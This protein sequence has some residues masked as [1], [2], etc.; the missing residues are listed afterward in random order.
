MITKQACSAVGNKPVDRHAGWLEKHRGVCAELFCHINTCLSWHALCPLPLFVDGWRQNNTQYHGNTQDTSSRRC[1]LSV[2]PG[3]KIRP[4]S[5]WSGGSRVRL[6]TRGCPAAAVAGD[7][8]TTA[9]QESL[10]TSATPPGWKL[11]APSSPTASAP[12]DLQ[13]A[14]FFLSNSSIC[15]C[16]CQ[17]KSQCFHS[18]KRSSFEFADL[19]SCALFCCA[20]VL[21]VCHCPMH[22]MVCNV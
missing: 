7:T 8:S 18:N 9:S 13:Y 15:I 4:H 5:V 19:I 21:T 20:R 12:G 14:L 17:S 3:C 16:A 11:S 2:S 10:P 6:Q 1:Y 22:L